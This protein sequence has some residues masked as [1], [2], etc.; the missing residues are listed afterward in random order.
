LNLPYAEAVFDLS[1]FRQNPHPFYTLAHELYP[2][3]YRPTITHSFISLLHKKKLLLKLFTQNIDCLE[4][5]AGLPGDMIV[6]AHGSFA[7]QRCIEC[8]TA[9]SDT[10]MREHISRKEVPHCESCQGL[11]KPDI[12]FFGEQLPEAYFANRTLPGRADLCIVMGTSLT[13]QPFA[14]LPSYCA[15]HVPRVLINLEEAGSLGSRADDVLLLGDCDTQ[16]RKLAEA[17]GWLEELE[18]MWAAT[19]P[20]AALDRLDGK[21]EEKAKPEKPKTADELLEEEVRKLTKEVEETLKLTQNH[22]ERVRKGLEKGEKPEVLKEQIKK[23]VETGSKDT[24]TAPLVEEE[25]RPKEKLEGGDEDLE[26]VFPH[27]KGKSI[28]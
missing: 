5:E 17:C 25:S 28:L 13:V 7:T 24:A 22:E 15:F 16:V 9:F 11:V 6:E 12:V 3:K 20:K 18:E 8:R 21:K 2:G 27:L 14:S 1:Y 4:R 19:A 10:A 26:H 23:E